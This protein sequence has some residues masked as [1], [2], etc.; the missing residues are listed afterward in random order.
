MCSLM[1]GLLQLCLEAAEDIS[2][3]LDLV[4]TGHLLQDD[5]VLLH[6][7]NEAIPKLPVNDVIVGGIH[8][9]P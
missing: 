4:G 5:L 7:L 8:D 6:E 2:P 1:W 9:A 3:Y